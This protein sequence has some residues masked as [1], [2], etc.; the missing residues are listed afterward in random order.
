MFKLLVITGSLPAGW[1]FITARRAIST[2]SGG[3]ICFR[4]PGARW[5]VHTRA[6][7]PHVASTVQTVIATLIVLLFFITGKDPYAD[8]YTAAEISS[9]SIQKYGGQNSFPMLPDVSHALKNSSLLD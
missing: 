5:V 1:R 2:R 9:C 4:L 3:K 7:A 6:T 8:I